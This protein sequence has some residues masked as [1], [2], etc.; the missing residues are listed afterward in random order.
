MPTLFGSFH[1]SYLALPLLAFV[2]RV[3]NEWLHERK[4]TVN[5]R[6]DEIRSWQDRHQP[7]YEEEEE[8]EESLVRRNMGRSKDT[9]Y[10][11]GN[12][13]AKKGRGQQDDEGLADLEQE[14]RDKDS[15]SH[16]PPPTKLSHAFMALVDSITSEYD[17]LDKA[18]YL[19]LK[20]ASG[21]QLK[22]FDIFQEDI[23][24]S[25]VTLRCI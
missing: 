15:T 5:A 25:V 14:Q 12:V 6:L 17:L 23:G 19:Q 3:F 18:P 11:Y 24:Q 2:R 21:I 1:L 16:V 4:T 22:L 8:E 13:D 10:L 7:I 20:F 9:G